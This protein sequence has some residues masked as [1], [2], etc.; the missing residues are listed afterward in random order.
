MK[1]TLMDHDVPKGQDRLI[2]A[3]KEYHKLLQN[4]EI[5]K[6]KRWLIHFDALNGAK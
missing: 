6:T 4:R 2:P 3:S 5:Q 1:T